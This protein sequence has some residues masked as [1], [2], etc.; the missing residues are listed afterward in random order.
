VVVLRCVGADEGFD[1]LA[2]GLSFLDASFLRS[3]LRDSAFCPGVAVEEVLVVDRVWCLFGSGDG[4]GGF[5]WRL[6]G[7]I[8]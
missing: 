1:A 2:L 3:F 5:D 8:V 4:F 7:G 6:L